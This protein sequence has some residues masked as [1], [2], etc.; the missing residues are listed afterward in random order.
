M[1]L[2]Q[3]R[4]YSDSGKIDHYVGQAHLRRLGKTGIFVDVIKSK[5]SDLQKWRLFG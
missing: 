2:G 5:N 1:I 3:Y 4:G